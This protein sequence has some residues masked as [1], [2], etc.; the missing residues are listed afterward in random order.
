MTPCRRFAGFRRVVSPVPCVIGSPILGTPQRHKYDMYLRRG[1]T[2]YMLGQYLTLA[3]KHLV[4]LKSGAGDSADASSAD[5]GVWYRSH[6]RGVPSALSGDLELHRIR[7][8][9]RVSVLNGLCRATKTARQFVRFAAL[10]GLG[11]LPLDTKSENSCL[12]RKSST[13]GH[14]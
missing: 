12:P 14:P 8:R 11:R 9:F 10:L 4:T 1:I 13:A 2:S 6:P 3:R 5:A 7:A